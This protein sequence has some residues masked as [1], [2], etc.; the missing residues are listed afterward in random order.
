MRDG[1]IP[2]TMV[3]GGKHFPSAINEMN[4]LE[5]KG[6]KRG[7]KPSQRTFIWNL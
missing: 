5:L 6:H 2:F 4:L 7:L 3:M 1:S